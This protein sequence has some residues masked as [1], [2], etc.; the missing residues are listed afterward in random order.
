MM[1]RST[2][3]S[4]QRPDK[5]MQDR[6]RQFDEIFLQR[7]AG[8]YI[9]VNRVGSAVGQR[10]PVFRRKQTSLDRRAW[11]G[12]G[13]PSAPTPDVSATGREEKRTQRLADVRADTLAKPEERH[14]KL[15]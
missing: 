15:Y 5:L 1:A 8:P 11:E 6:R 7:T 14:Q 10:L 3:R 9:R 13:H 12:W 2:T 4:N